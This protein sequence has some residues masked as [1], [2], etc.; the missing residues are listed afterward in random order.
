MRLRVREDDVDTCISSFVFR[1]FC[2]NP[3]PKW[4]SDQNIAYTYGDSSTLAG[5]SACA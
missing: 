3:S 2:S 1:D 4:C 5:T